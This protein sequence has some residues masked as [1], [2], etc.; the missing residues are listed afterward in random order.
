M[1]GSLRGSLEFTVQTLRKLA[2][3]CDATALASSVLPVPGGPNSRHPFG[4]V[5]P[6]RWNS[7]GFIKG[8]SIT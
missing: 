3:S 5:I 6:T 8:N 1:I 4:G 2:S 7:S